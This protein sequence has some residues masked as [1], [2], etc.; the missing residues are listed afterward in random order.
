MDVWIKKKN[1]H[2][3]CIYLKIDFC[4]H[5][6]DNDNLI[7]ILISQKFHSRQQYE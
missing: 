1:Q 3:L 4:I 7:L 2:S 5:L 6:L